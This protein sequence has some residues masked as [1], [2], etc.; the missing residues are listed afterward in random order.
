VSPAVGTIP[1]A[2]EGCVRERGVNRCDV[3]IYNRCNWTCGR[4]CRI[5]ELGLVIFTAAKEI[6]DKT[7]FPK[8]CRLPSSWKDPVDDVPDRA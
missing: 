8:G 4:W 3:A 7:F 6:S 2:D 5:P 1:T